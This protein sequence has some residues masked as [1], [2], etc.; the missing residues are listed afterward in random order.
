MMTKKEQ[1]KR[2]KKEGKNKNKQKPLIP[3][4]TL[5]APLK[6]LSFA[7]LSSDLASQGRAKWQ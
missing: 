7:S 6:L 1:K 4:L 3:P 2:D 5:P